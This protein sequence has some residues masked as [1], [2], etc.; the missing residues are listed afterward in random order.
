MSM[1]R[2][3]KFLV[4][5]ILSFFSA[6][7]SSPAQDTLMTM[8]KAVE[9]LLKNNFSILISRNETEIAKNNNTPGNAGELPEIN[10]YATQS[11]AV[12]KTRQSYSSGLELDKDNIKTDN[13]NAGVALNWT[14]FDGF[15]MFATKNKLS[16]LEAQGELNLKIQIENAIVLAVQTYY[17][18]IQ[19]EEIVKALHED[20][21]VS[22]E[23]AKIADRKFANGSGAKLDLLQAKV[24]LN[25]QRSALLK[26]QTLLEEA[27]VNLN[28]LLARPLDTKFGV[29]DT[30]IISYHPTIEQLNATVYQRNNEL[31]FSEKNIRI[32]EL[33]LRQ[34]Q[35]QRY[36]TISLAGNYLYSKTDNQAGFVLLNQNLGFNYGFTA[37]MPLFN[38]FVINS[39]VKN[40]KL[41]VTNSQL[42]FNQ[43]KLGVS[44]SLMNGFREFEDNLAILKLEEENIQ[45]ARES[46][47]IAL[48]RFRVGLSTFVDLTIAQT[49][50]E[51]SIV[52]LVSARYNAKLS[53]TN[54]MKLNGDLVK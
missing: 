35:A 44:A 22:E 46:M 33:N 18:I 12:N 30:V 7:Q 27:K 34:I 15:K 42:Q 28:Q 39:Q 31:L 1:Y 5:L 13:L 25:A 40:A 50:F 19:Q 45:Y 36:P 2:L 43:T 16:E 8:E 14:I 52:R 54:L 11:S 51:N 53:E 3:K 49:G 38:G 6:L 24:D 48:E 17:N 10:A 41:G 21:A 29:E 26:Q 23:R 20:I 9:I 4:L 47:N 37:S 32:S